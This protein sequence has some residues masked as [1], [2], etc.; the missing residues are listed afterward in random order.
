MQ[1][2]SKKVFYYHADANSLGGF[3]E[4]ALKRSF[5][6]HPRYPCPQWVVI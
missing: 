1:S 6:M 4:A 5:Q 3:I 2:N